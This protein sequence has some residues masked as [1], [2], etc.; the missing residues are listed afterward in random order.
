MVGDVEGRPTISARFEEAAPIAGRTMVTAFSNGQRLTA[1]SAVR[2]AGEAI[3]VNF[4]SL[5]RPYVVEAIGDEHLVARVAV[6][7]HGP[8]V[9]DAVLPV[10][11]DVLQAEDEVPLARLDRGDPPRLALS[12]EVGK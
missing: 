12:H 9:G 5:R 3:T 6:V 2:G 8:P 7:I 4:R 11:E 10:A 1:L